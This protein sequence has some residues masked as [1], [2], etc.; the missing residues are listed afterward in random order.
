ML[1][2]AKHMRRGA[3][4]LVPNVGSQAYD[5]GQFTS[6]CDVQGSCLIFTCW[7]FKFKMQIQGSM[8]AY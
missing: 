6:K 3:G 1:T 4:A 8:Q 7:H 2:C 5:L